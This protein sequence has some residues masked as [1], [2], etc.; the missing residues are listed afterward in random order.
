MI[1][2]IYKQGFGSLYRVI[3]KRC[4]HDSLLDNQNGI[5]FQSCN[6]V[7]VNV[8]AYKTGQNSIYRHQLPSRTLI[9]HHARAR[10][11]ATLLTLIFKIGQGA[12]PFLF[13]LYVTPLVLQVY[14]RD[15]SGSLDNPNMDSQSEIMNYHSDFLI[16][17]TFRISSPIGNISFTLPLYQ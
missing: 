3:S 5:G 15:H 8:L 14:F 12:S 1:A 9:N 4:S 6:S 2:D 7:N 17:S 11:I 13:S 16:G 10:I